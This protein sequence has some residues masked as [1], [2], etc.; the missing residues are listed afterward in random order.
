MKNQRLYPEVQPPKSRLGLTVIVPG[1]E[2][3]KCKRNRGDSGGRE[4]GRGWRGSPGVFCVLQE[5]GVITLLGHR[6]LL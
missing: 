6:S 4:C 3:S 1:G 5:Q 2:R